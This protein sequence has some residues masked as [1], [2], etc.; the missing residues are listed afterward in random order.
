MKKIYL[1]SG[2]IL[3]FL[4]I[5]VFKNINVKPENVAKQTFT[6]LI[7]SDQKK[8][9][10]EIYKILKKTPYNKRRDFEQEWEIMKENKNIYFWSNY[11]MAIT[12]EFN[13]KKDQYVI[14]F[15]SKTDKKFELKKFERGDFILSLSSAK[16]SYNKSGYIKIFSKYP[17]MAKERSSYFSFDKDGLEFLQ[18]KTIDSTKDYYK[19]V[20][21]LLKQG[22]FKEVMQIDEK[23]KFYKN[24]KEDYLKTAKLC[25]RS[26]DT[27]SI[28][29]FNKGHINEATSVLKYGINEYL[30]AQIDTPLDLQYADFLDKLL[31]D[32]ENLEVS[33]RISAREF[34]K[35]LNNYAYFLMNKR[36][37]SDARTIL[38]KVKDIDANRTV[39]YGNLG[40]VHWNLKKYKEAID[41]YKKYVELM[42]GVENPKIPEKIKIRI[43]LDPNNIPIEY[44]KEN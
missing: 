11:A 5:F 33:H 21:K 43:Y 26:A 4:V 12:Y 13:R 40:D 28:S 9:I 15:F 27:Y 17:F 34:A 23:P 10:D 44:L 36:M 42:G 8:E 30:M 32:P 37:Y 38:L 41:Y 24:Y 7:Y 14:W 39:N 3:F 22:K 2:M 16:A 35:I 18:T 19:K 29:E 6:Q 25:I 1:I 20:N 31:K